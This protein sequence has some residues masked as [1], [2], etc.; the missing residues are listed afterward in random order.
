MPTQIQ[1]L[2]FLKSQKPFLSNT[3]QVSKLG[4]F[5]SYAQGTQTTES[6]VDILLEFEDGTE[7]LLD[8]RLSL[9][10]FFQANLGLKVDIARERFLRRSVRDKILRHAIFV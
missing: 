3:Y 5:G 4:L 1:V 2:D 8:K 6:D 10:A 9:E 7:D